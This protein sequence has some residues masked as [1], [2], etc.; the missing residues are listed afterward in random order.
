MGAATFV[1]AEMLQVDYGCLALA[2]LI[3]ATA[4]HVA[5][6][7]PVELRARKTGAGSL[8]K[9]DLEP[10]QPLAACPHLLPPPRVLVG[11]SVAGHS[12]TY[13]AVI[14]S[15]SCLVVCNSRRARRLTWR[16]LV[17][18]VAE[19]TRQAIQVAV[20][21]AAIGIIVA[22]A[23]QLK[24]TLK[25]S[26]QLMA[27]ACGPLLGAMGLITA[28][29]SVMGTG[30]PTV[31]AYVIGAILLASAHLKVGVPEMSAHFFVMYYCVLSML[32]PPVALASFAAAGIAG[33]GAKETSVYAFRLSCDSL[34]IPVALALDP[35]LPGKGNLIGVV[36]AFLSLVA[37][38]MVWAVAVVGSWKRGSRGVERIWPEATAAGVVYAPTGTT[39]RL[40]SL[41]ALALVG[42]W[43]LVAGDWRLSSRS[44]ASLEGSDSDPKRIH[45]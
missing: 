36:A 17:G 29:W 27:C 28:G 1:M 23:I 11:M 25:S 12:P 30:L 35:R 22:V 5:V 7:P 6:F 32:T 10:Q 26:M 14:A 4:F 15:L 38:T 41:G 19:P 37:G 39:E 20:P 21:I 44:Q 24:V 42:L 33:G 31:A 18:R 13:A 16:A 9:Q 43:L 45:R 40:G 8:P 34:R 3:P 2:G